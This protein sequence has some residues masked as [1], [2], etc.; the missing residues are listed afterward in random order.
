[1]WLLLVDKKTM[2][3]VGSSGL[4]KAVW[5]VP[6]MEV[7][8]WVRSSCRGQGYITEAVQAIIS[9]MAFVNFQ[10]QRLEIRTDSNNKRSKAVAVRSGFQLEATL[11]NYDR[12]HL[13]N[14]L[15]DIDIFVKFPHV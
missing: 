10:A 14:K 2:K 13:T 3:M 12:H 8:Y 9:C 1:M 11:K 6:R 15:I 4:H 7:G 5:H